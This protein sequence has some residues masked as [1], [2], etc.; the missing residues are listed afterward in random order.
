M[1]RNEQGGYCM[2]DVHMGRL[3][4]VAHAVSMVF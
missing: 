4:N 1:K 3:A 2:N